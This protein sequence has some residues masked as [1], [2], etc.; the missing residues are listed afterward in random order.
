MSKIFI[1]IDRQNL[2]KTKIEI[3]GQELSNVIKGL[4]FE[5]RP[6][7]LP[8]LC[9]DFVAEYVE[10]LAESEVTTL[11]DKSVKRVLVTSKPSEATKAKVFIK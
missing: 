8:H 3:D 5:A 4:K 1:S 7:E 10:I 9:V 2:S 11:N 6:G